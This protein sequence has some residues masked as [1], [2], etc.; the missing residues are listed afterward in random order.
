MCKRIQQLAQPVIIRFKF[1]LHHMLIFITDKA[2]FPGALFAIAL[3]FRINVKS[4]C[5][6]IRRLETEWL[7][8][9][10]QLFCIFR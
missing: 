3:V 4:Q 9:S 7:Q 8:N 2:L 10:F 1:H 5:F 6:Q